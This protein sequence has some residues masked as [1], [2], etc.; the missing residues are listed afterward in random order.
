MNTPELQVNEPPLVGRKYAFATA[1]LLLGIASCVSLLGFEKGILAVI[2]G[3]LA[4][5]AQPQPALA[6]RRS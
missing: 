6:A 4:L 1:S 5:R 3:I 2:F